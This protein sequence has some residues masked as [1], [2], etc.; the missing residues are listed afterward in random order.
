MIRALAERLERERWISVEERLP[1]KTGKYLCRYTFQQ[2]GVLSEFRTTGALYY[3]ANAPDPH[4]QHASSGLYVT[5]WRE[6][7]EP[8]EGDHY[9]SI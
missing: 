4:W 3:E 2:D 1:E 9:E 5:H 6:L 7:P 8:P